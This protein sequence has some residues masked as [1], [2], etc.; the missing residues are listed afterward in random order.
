MT[1]ELSFSLFDIV[2]SAWFKGMQEML[3]D[4]IIQLVTQAFQ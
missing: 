2:L 1:H 4:V 3:V